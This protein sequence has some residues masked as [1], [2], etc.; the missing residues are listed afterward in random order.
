MFDD[1]ADVVAVE[2]FSGPHRRC[3]NSVRRV[4]PAVGERRSQN[5]V[6]TRM[7]SDEGGDVLGVRG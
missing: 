4:G 3:G 1:K 7:S 2:G 5:G 6:L